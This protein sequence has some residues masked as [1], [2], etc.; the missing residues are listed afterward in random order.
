MKR[1]AQ[2]AAGSAAMFGAAPLVY[3]TPHN[4]GFVFVTLF[5]GAMYATALVQHWLH[6]RYSR[7]G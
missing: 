3:G 5:V 4:H 7:R 1:L 6:W 2:I